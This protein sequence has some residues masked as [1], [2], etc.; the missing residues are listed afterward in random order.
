MRQGAGGCCTGMIQRDGMGR[1]VGG[2]FRMGNTGIS[3]ADAC[4]C[5]A[6]ATTIL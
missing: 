5:M 1:A 4:E 6:K 3:M 2:R